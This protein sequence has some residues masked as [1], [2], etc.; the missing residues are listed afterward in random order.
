MS[1]EESSEVDEPRTQDRLSGLEDKLPPAEKK[2]VDPVEEPVEEI[3]P[4]PEEVEWD[5]DYEEH[6]D[7]EEPVVRKPKKKRH[8]GAFIALIVV[9]VFL[10]VWTIASPKVMPQSGDRYL[11]DPD[12][13]SLGGF[14]GDVDTWAGNTTWGL[15]IGG[16]TNASVGE[17][18][19]INVLVTKVYEHPSSWWFVGTGIS[20]RNVSLVQNDG[21]VIGTVTSRAD[22]GYGRLTTIGLSFSEP[23]D[24]ELYV[25]V[26][27]T[28]YADM[29]IGFLPIKVVQ[30]TSDPFTI[31]VA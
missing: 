4:P 12:D 28:V 14:S 27:F 24:Y 31:H 11:N 23:G 2:A 30:M 21:S 17:V 20:F 15:S 9:I 8:Y 16:P 5:E 3:P 26:K 25:Y 18:I 13:A 22:L 7:G 29:K 1:P 10:L 6:I 19:S